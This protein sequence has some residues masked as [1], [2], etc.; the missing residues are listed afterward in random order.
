M[1]YLTIEH[2]KTKKD[3]NILIITDHYSRF[4]QAIKTPNQTALATAQAAW[5]HFFQ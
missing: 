2:G 4:A 5:D 1:D 3:V